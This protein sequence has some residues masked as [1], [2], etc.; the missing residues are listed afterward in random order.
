MAFS[1]GGAAAS[2]KAVSVEAGLVYG[3]N[4][5]FGC[6]ASACM[7]YET[8]VSASGFVNFDISTSYQGFPGFSVVTSQG[9]DTPFVKLGFQ[10]SQSWS[11]D[12]PK[13]GL[14]GPGDIIA[15]R[16][17]GTSSGLSYGVGLSPVTAGAALC[18]TAVLDGQNPLD[19][20]NGIED[21]L[22]KWAAVGFDPRQMPDRLRR[23]GVAGSAPSRA[24]P[25]IALRGAHGNYLSAEDN[26]NASA[27]VKWLRSWERWTLTD[28]NGGNLMHGDVI[29]LRGHHGKYLVAEASHEA[30]ANRIYAREWERWLIT[31]DGRSTG[32]RIR[33]GDRISLRSHHHRYLVAE[34]DGRARAD[35]QSIGKWEKW[36]LTF[37]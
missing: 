8:D 9:V 18:F 16:L 3:E 12:P 34:P 24:G 7:G 5:Q 35:R 32:Q 10:T 36:A 28:L 29:T 15:K 4:G 23:L 31:A 20:F 37:R 17:I 30:N 27:R 1:T 22:G 6:F 21:L 14:R 25:A 26:G 2:G 11:A 33:N 13:R 19:Q